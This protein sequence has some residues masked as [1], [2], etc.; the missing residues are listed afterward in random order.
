LTVLALV[1]GAL[2]HLN[3]LGN[4]PLFDDH[5]LVGNRSLSEV[6]ALK[7]LLTEPGMTDSPVFAHHYRPLLMLAYWINV[8]ISG[9]SAPSLRAG[10]LLVH[11][12]CGLLIGV[13]ARRILSTRDPPD[14]AA[15]YSGV[16]VTAIFVLHPVFGEAVNLVL[17]R[18][19]SLSAL[20]MMAALLALERS[21]RPQARAAIWWGV[22]LASGG[23]AMLVK[24][25]AIVM[26]LLVL[27]Y[28]ARRGLWGGQPARMA[29]AAA[30]FA[31]VPLLYVALW[32]PAA[33]V[34]PGWGPRLGYLMA[35]PAALLDYA[36]MLL[37]PHRVAIAGGAGSGGWPPGPW[38]V[39]GAGAVVA[40]L[41]GA[42]I[43]RRRW[44]VCFFSALWAACCL[45]PS[46][47]LIPLKLTADPIRLYL[48]SLGLLALAASGLLR[49]G[50]LL[51]DR[52]R[53]RGLT[54]PPA[55]AMVAASPTL[56]VCLYLF[57]CALANNDR[58][59]DALVA[60]RHAVEVYPRSP[61]ASGNLCA[62]L[63]H[64]GPLSAARAACRRAL[65]LAPR[66]PWV[67]MAIVMIHHRDGD[68][69]AARRALADARR[70]AGNSWQL[71]LADGFLAWTGGDCE[72][73]ERAYAAVL[74]VYPR[75]VHARLRLADCRLRRGGPGVRALLAPL[76]RQP[77]AE[78]ADRRLMEAL[79]RRLEKR[80]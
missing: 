6:G 56:F 67:N 21:T 36:R 47:S 62:T 78:A 2:V 66:D 69:R 14:P 26:P 16:V 22:A 45:A 18:N 43:L 13:L 9:Q 27:L 4:P 11:L 30:L 28:A 61:T 57:V 25:T 80:R 50:R 73:A 75:N 53:A 17:K 29:A 1:V 12:L 33:T 48:A 54:R 58:R 20:L 32:F 19:S 37:D 59:G 79:L 51:G 68:R 72:R 64:R 42:V 23:A 76:R 35:Q 41:A 52:L 10:N 71:S 38:S 31:A 49:L 55:L 60:W 15:A 39:A 34:P 46:S 7:R 77:P 5:F 44:P 63:Y 24:E 8:Q 65:A 74:A 3:A 40:L 70:R